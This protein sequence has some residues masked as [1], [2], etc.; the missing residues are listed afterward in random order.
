MARKPNYQFDRYERER[1]K[2]EKKAERMNAKQKNANEKKRE[3]PK[4]SPLDAPKI[5][6]WEPQRHQSLQDHH[7]K[8]MKISARDTPNRAGELSI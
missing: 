4:D 7:R 8:G 1:K 6:T 5:M 2:D 3:E